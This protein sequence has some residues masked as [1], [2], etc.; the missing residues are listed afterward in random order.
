MNTPNTTTVSQPNV[1]AF[2]SNY[3]DTRQLVNRID[4]ALANVDG[5]L[6]QID[7]AEYP[8]ELSVIVPV[9]NERQTLPKILERIDEVMPESTQVIVID[10]ASTD[11]TSVW[12]ASLPQRSNRKILRRICNHGKGSAVR[13]GIRHSQGR[14]VAIQDADTEYDPKDLLQ[15]IEPVLKGDEDVVYGSR[16]LGEIDDPSWVHRFGNWVLTASSNCMTGQ[17]LTDMETCHKAFRGDLVRSISIRECRFGFEPEIT[18]KVAARGVRIAE[19][20]TGYEYR[21][22][23][24]GKKI[25]WKDGVAA[26]AC[27]WRYRNRGWFRRG[28]QGIGRLAKR[29]LVRKES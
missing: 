16:Y 19:V 15:V 5:Q 17:R 25:T 13:L 7:Q 27:M 26:F 8:F 10:D 11:G 9:F 4:D 12:L 1:S 24:E 6:E 28:F 23:E 3:A 29:T 14:V 18:S 20:P 21:S 2:D 22:Y